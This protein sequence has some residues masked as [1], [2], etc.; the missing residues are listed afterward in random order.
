VR[1][2]SSI[3]GAE[4]TVGEKSGLV[5]GIT[6]FLR[7]GCCKAI[8]PRTYERAKLMYV[9]GPASSSGPVEPCQRSEELRVHSAF[10]ATTQA[11]YELDI[12]QIK[13]TCIN[14]KNAHDLQPE[15]VMVGG[16][17]YGSSA[18][19]PEFVTRTACM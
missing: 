1:A 3:N 16:D 6:A 17:K 18:T 11:T 14:D 9:V 4:E 10:P 2:F 15:Q 13:G 19:L 8:P 12:S 5:T 7:D